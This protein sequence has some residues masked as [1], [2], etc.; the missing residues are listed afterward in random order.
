MEARTITDM[1][2]YQQNNKIERLEVER[3]SIITNATKNMSGK[4]G[5]P[6]LQGIRF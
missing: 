1:V 6:T 2:T 4:S 5:I 3:P